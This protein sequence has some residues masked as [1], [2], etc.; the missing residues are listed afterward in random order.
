VAV[1]PR[2]EPRDVTIGRRR[3]TVE[4]GPRGRA[5]ARVDAV[6]E[7]RVEVNIEIRGP[8]PRGGGSG[9]RL[10]KGLDLATSCRYLS[11]NQKELDLSTYARCLAIAPMMD[12]T[13]KYTTSDSYGSLCANTAH[14]SSASLPFS[15]LRWSY[16]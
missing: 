12:G 7:Q 8:A 13:Y 4:T 6:E 9:A 1:E 2:E 5:R 14:E 3:Q 10:R 15:F 11:R 16:R